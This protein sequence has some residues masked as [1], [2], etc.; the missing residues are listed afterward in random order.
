MD[1]LL[2]IDSWSCRVTALRRLKVKRKMYLLSFSCRRKFP[3]PARQSFF[4]RAPTAF[5]NTDN[6][7]VCYNSRRQYN[8]KET[9]FRNERSHT[10]N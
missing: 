6:R 5:S 1:E 2:F 8:A 4:A 7:I 10:K 9:S 3:V